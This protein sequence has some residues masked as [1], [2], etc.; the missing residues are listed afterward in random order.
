MVPYVRVTSS[1]LTLSMRPLEN[2]QNEAP[3]LFLPPLF[4]FGMYRHC[5]YFQILS[6]GT[7]QFIGF[8]SRRGSVKTYSSPTRAAL[9]ADMLNYGGAVGDVLV[10]RSP[11]SN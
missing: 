4:F 7:C 2:Y 6:L 9:F 5:T 11:K 8:Q 1:A 3:L 10:L